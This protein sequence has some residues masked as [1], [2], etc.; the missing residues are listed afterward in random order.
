MPMPNMPWEQFR[1]DM[2]AAGYDEVLER[3]WAPDT[4]LATHAH[5]FEA[6]ALVVQGEMWLAVAGKPAQRLLPGD[7]FHLEPEVP[8]DER[9]GSQGATYWVA[10]KNGERSLVSWCI[11][12][13]GEGIASGLDSWKVSMQ[14]D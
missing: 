1:A 3:Q 2:L 13:D 11:P 8:H 6:N 14:H 4:V 7:R 5:P 9:Y 12:L 10:R